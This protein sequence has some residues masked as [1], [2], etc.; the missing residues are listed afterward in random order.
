MYAGKEVERIERAR[1]LK[2]IQ[3]ERVDD[4]PLIIHWLK[5]M[6]IA[7]IIDRELPVPHG[8]RK[9]LSYGQL[10]VLFLSY[11]AS[12]SD[13][14][15]CAVET[16]VKKHRRTLEMATGWNI[17]VKDATDDR[18]ADLLSIIG[19]SSPQEREN[20]ALKLGQKTIRAYEL[21]TDKARSDTT[22]FSVYHQVETETENL[23]K[24]GYS[25]D[26]R[27]DLVQYRQMLA[28]LD[29]MGMPLLG[30]TLPGNKT[31]EGDYVPT[32]RQLAQIIGHK[33][34]LFLADS[35]ASTWNNRALIDTEGGIYCFPL[36]MVKPRPHLLWQWVTN[37]PILVEE[38]YLNEDDD[39][40]WPIGEGFE[41]P[42]GSIWW[43]KENQQWY[44]WAERWLVVCS[45]ALRERQLKSLSTR[46]SKA[47]SA[48]AKLV[49]KT[50]QD[51]VM[52][53]TKVEQIL[54]RYRVSEQIL[55]NIEKKISYQKV[56]EGAG[57][58]SQNR[59]FR[60]VRQTTLSLTYQR[61]Q[62]KISEQQSIAGWRLY[63]TNAETT[64]L[65][66]AQAVNSY[67]EQWQ[68]ERGFH[69]F[70]RGH[71]PALP[72]Y[73]QDERRIRGLMFLLT[74]ALTLF[75]LM[76]FVVRRQLTESEQS[77]S[78][79]Y[80][81]N[82]KRSTFRPTAEQLLAAFAD[83]TLYLYPDGSTEISSLNF[84]QRQ[85]LNLMKIPE[86]IYLVPQLVPN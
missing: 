15:L 61:C 66:L 84:L 52:L 28:T 39:S 76:E 50:P 75:T 12:Q 82:P 37:S 62:A 9:G 4:L 45:Y 8:N 46:L 41:V 26:R 21:P 24:F 19:S 38:I 16:W 64:R 29:P 2:D 65:S 44:R 49:Q 34:F 30:A 74:I 32:W 58:G 31:D 73:F 54:K 43:S 47:E 81:G 72:I 68:P 40:E 13:H 48:L 67:R 86:S 85:I 14:R 17:G 25:K 79:L 23:L 33:D 1:F 80:S 70:K 56:Y 60:R 5:Q 27:P 18:L 55:I 71:L 35:K 63:V 53:Q 69:R 10:S 3:S 36:A 78:G 6:E 22:S 42:L 20:I 7:S 51:E 57:R 77:I 11:V 59:P 83:L